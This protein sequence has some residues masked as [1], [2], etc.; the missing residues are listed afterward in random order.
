MEFLPYEIIVNIINNIDIYDIVSF[1][2]ASAKFT[3]ITIDEIFW[4][5][6]IKKEFPKICNEDYRVDSN[7]KK[8]LITKEK[9]MIY[10]KNMMDLCVKLIKYKKK[11]LDEILDKN[12]ELIRNDFKHAA[13]NLINLKNSPIYY[14]V[15]WVNTNVILNTISINRYGIIKYDYT[16]NDYITKNFSTGEG[17]NIDSYKNKYLEKGYININKNLLNE[18]CIVDAEYL[19][20]IEYKSI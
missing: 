17:E 4:T 3:N 7:G 12:N 8:Y 11:K 6:R 10:Y 5:K 16:K 20:I 15:T 2:C 13:I 14:D 19:S 9:K 1:T 18:I